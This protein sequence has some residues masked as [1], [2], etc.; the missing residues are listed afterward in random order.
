MLAQ[1]LGGLLTQING[2]KMVIGMDID[3]ANKFCTDKTVTSD[4]G[5]KTV[6]K[7]VRVVDEDGNALMVTEDYREDRVNVKT[8]G[9]KITEIV[10]YA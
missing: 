7:N 1:A 3:S 9:G 5:N 6:I 8:V 2:A 4:D 10:N